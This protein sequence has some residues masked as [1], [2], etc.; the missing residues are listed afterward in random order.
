MF[1]YIWKIRLIVLLFKNR[2]TDLV[3]CLFCFWIKINSSSLQQ[4][5][6]IWNT[7]FPQL[8]SD[9]RISKVLP[10]TLN[11]FTAQQ[12]SH[13]SVWGSIAFWFLFCVVYQYMWPA[14]SFG[15][16]FFR[17]FWNIAMSP[18]FWFGC[19]MFPFVAL[20]SDVMFKMWVLLWRHFLNDVTKFAN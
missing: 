12:C 17:I 6:V 10:C 3:H 13:V 18:H 9:K 1:S 14:T 15:D 19:L 11:S 4:Q 8:Y 7:L 5:H 16:F 20:F 2:L